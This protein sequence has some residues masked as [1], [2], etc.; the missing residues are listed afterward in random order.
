MQGQE[1]PGGQPILEAKVF[2][3]KADAC[4]RSAVS[5]RGSQQGGFAGGGRDQAH[6]H[7]DRGGLAGSVRSQES[8]HLTLLD[9]QGEAFYSGVVA[10]YFS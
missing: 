9:L 3:Q 6:Q 7:L 8:K 2:G 4:P 1:L 5:E 10:E